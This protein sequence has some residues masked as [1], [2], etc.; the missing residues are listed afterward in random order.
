MALSAEEQ[1]SLK[2]LVPASPMI[3]R[4]TDGYSQLQEIPSESIIEED[5]QDIKHQNPLASFSLLKKKPTDAVLPDHKTISVN[6]LKN[7]EQIMV[8]QDYVRTQYDKNIQL[9]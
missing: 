3:K 2:N 5:E 1:E 9:V 8:L 6:L 7:F 4:R